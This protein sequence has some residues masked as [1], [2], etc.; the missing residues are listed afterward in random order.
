V[1]RILAR[2]GPVELLERRAR[3]LMLPGNDIPRRT[4]REALSLLKQCRK[5]LRRL[6]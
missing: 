2:M 6:A 3:E 4:R 5:K 1:D